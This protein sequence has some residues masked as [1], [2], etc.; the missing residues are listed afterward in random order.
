M[1]EALNIILPI[2]FVGIVFL[3]MLRKGRVEGFKQD[4]IPTKDFQQS[5]A[6]K[7]LIR[8]QQQHNQD[9]YERHNKS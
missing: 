3:L 6:E 5:E 4:D 9:F 2:L 7:A 1:S 8:A